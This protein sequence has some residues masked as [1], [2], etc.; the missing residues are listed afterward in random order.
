MAY[1][2]SASAPV[3]TSQSFGG[4]AGKEFMYRSADASSLVLASSYFSD[5]YTRGMRVGDLVLLSGVST[6][7]TF[8]YTIRAGVSAVS[9]A[10]GG[11]SL[12]V[13]TTS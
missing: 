11:V 12:T 4:V 9:T 1:V 10:S 8:M 7:S 13:T 3:L 6:G 5:G 2:S